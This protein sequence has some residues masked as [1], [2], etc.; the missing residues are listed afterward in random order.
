MVSRLAQKGNLQTLPPD[1]VNKPKVLFARRKT[2]SGGSSNNINPLAAWAAK[3]LQGKP[4]LQ[5]VSPSFKN[6]NK[7]NSYAAL[8]R[9]FCFPTVRR[10]PL[11]PNTVAV[12]LATVSTQETTPSQASTR[13]PSASAGLLALG[14]EVPLVAPVLREDL[15]RSEGSGLVASWGFNMAGVSSWGWTPKMVVSLVV[16]L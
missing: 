12:F 14:F 16:P 4:I 1:W 11:L 6:K 10:N 13:P 8:P 3:V 2:R 15:A 9:V 7:K 5:L